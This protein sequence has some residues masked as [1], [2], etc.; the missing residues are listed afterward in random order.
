MT[1]KDTSHL[2]GHYFF[3]SMFMDELDFLKNKFNIK[4]MLDIGCGLG[5]MVEFA[6]FIDIYSV[7]VDGDTTLG[8]KPYVIY[9]DFNDGEVQLEDKFDLV[10]S[11][12]FVEHVYEKFIPNYM[13]LFQKGNY[14][15]MSGA[16][17]G[18]G[19]YHHVN[20]QP[21]EYW[22]DKFAEY[23][24]RYDPDTVKEIIE[25]SKNKP[26]MEKNMLF[27]VNNNPHTITEYKKPFVVSNLEEML[28]HNISQFVARGGSV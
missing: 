16:T 28:H 10:Y 6:N 24:F 20:E 19:G 2:G 4:S 5:G 17:P 15:I 26:F 8:E 1:N 23:G 7:G 9:H 22:I 11:I 12:E 18:Q 14:V 21:R 13:P 3:T 27:F 25:V